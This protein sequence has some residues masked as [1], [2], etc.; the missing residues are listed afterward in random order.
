MSI[1]TL[2]RM[3]LLRLALLGA[4]I[5][6]AMVAPTVAPAD[7]APRTVAAAE[8]GPIATAAACP[9]AIR[10]GGRRYAYYQHRVK[11][12]RA[13][14]AVRRL[15]ATRGRDGTPR[16]FRCRSQSGFRRTGGCVN[17]S[18]TRYF[19]FHR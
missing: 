13:R 4:L 15:Y 16:G 10:L 19:G 5:C 11:C 9:D 3:T 8:S 2:S 18:R 6:L 12:R 14:R 17:S 7:S 1:S